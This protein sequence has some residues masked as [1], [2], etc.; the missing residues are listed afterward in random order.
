MAH[1]LRQRY[2]DLIAAKLRA[3][4][5]TKDNQIFNT[6]YEGSPLAGAVKIPVRDGETVVGDYSTTNLSGNTIKYGSTTYIT[7]VIGNDKYVNEFIDGYEA[8]AV[9]DN[10]IADRLDSAGYSL[11]ATA[12]TDGLLTLVRGVQG[13]DRAGSS[14][15]STD[16]RYQ[17]AGYVKAMTALTGSGSLSATDAYELVLELWQKLDEANVPQEGRYLIV[18]P[19]ARR[20]ILSSNKAIRQSDLSQE[21]IDKGIIAE[22]GGF[23]VYQSNRIPN[24]AKITISGTDYEG[25]VAMLAGHPQYATRIEEWRFLPQLVNLDGDQNVIGGSAIKGRLVLTHEVIKPEAFA[26]VTYPG[27]ALE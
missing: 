10:L 15:A 4:L 22:I 12:D 17:K 25:K 7:A 21:K 11:A 27:E 16:P 14:F 6:F 18:N 20:L 8:D 5:V 9:P 1:N 23:D 19:E 26:M 24:G 2:A 13:L 3:T